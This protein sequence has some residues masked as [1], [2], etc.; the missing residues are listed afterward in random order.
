MPPEARAVVELRR[1]LRDNEADA[2]VLDGLAAEVAAVSGR[3]GSLGPE[4]AAFLAVKLHAWYTA[5]ESILER[6]ARVVEG[7]L[8]GGPA[9]HQELLRGMTLP[10]AEVRPA[11]IDPV[12]L[13]DLSDILAFRHFFRHAYAVSLDAAE[14][15]RHASRLQGVHPGVRQDLRGFESLVRGWIQALEDGARP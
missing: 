3:E 10:L 15:R 14:L 4:A 13:P 6:I 1:L 5:F 8:P 11:V 9:H 7:G 12:R 2:A